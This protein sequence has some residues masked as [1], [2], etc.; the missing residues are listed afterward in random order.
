MPPILLLETST[1]VCSVALA[2]DDGILAFREI[3]EGYAHSENITVFIEETLNEAGIKMAD[4]AA[5][6]VSSGPGSYTGL[7][8]GVSTAKGICFA[9]DKPLIS[10]GTLDG[11]ASGFATTRDVTK[12]AFLVPMIDARR[13]EVYCSVYDAG[14][15]EVEPPQAKIIDGSSFSNYL[16]KG[17]VFFKSDRRVH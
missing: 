12:G 4:L 9:L 8:I 5:V 11:M 1:T 17:T 14:M 16:E 7:R 13:M 10:V 2:G 6:A 15:S 3:N